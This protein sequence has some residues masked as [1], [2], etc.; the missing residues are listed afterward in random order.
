M[1]RTLLGGEVAAIGSVQGVVIGGIGPFAGD[2]GL[3]YLR[4]NSV[5]ASDSLV[6]LVDILLGQSGVSI[7]IVL[8]RVRE[9]GRDGDSA[10]MAGDYR[11]PAGFRREQDHS[12]A[13]DRRRD[14][15]DGRHY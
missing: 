9:L 14:L 8:H 7:A 5:V 6:A 1:R 4:V 10:G 11:C 15:S 12:A 3:Y 13:R 2:P